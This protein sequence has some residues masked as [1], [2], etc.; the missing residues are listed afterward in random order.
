MSLSEKNIENLLHTIRNTF[1][2]RKNQDPLYI[3]LA[4]NLDRISAP[5]HQI[6]FGRRGSGKSC[7]MIHYLNQAQHKGVFPVYI[8]ADE[9]KKLT[10]PDILIRLLIHI[11]E[12]LLSAQPFLQ[13]HLN[14]KSPLR[15][16]IKILRNLLNS[17][18]TADVTEDIER[19]SAV[20]VEA[21]IPNPMG[22]AKATRGTKKSQGRTSR[23]KEKKLEAL[24]RQL[25]DHKRAI[26]FAINNINS[27]RACILLDDFYLLPRSWHPDVVD[28]LH[29]LVRDT[30]IYLKIA[31]IRHR[32][33]LSRNHPHTIGVELF[34][35][36]EEINL[37]RT[38]DDLETTQGYLA[39]MLNTMG[40]GCN[41]DKVTETHF[42]PNALQELTLASGGV[43]R[44]F[45]NIFVNSVEAALAEQ[46][47]RW[48]TPKWVWKGAGRLTYQTKLKNL[49]EDE[50]EATPGLE[51]VFVD[52]LRF[53]LTEKKKT[54]F[55]I[56]QDE[57]Q[58]RPME[59]EIIQ[60]LMDMKLIHV[61]EP[62]TSAASGRSGRYEAYT[63]DF[64]LF[65]E[66]RRRNIQI[67]EFWIRGEDSHRKGVRESPVYPLD[68]VYEAF[69]G[70][71]KVTPENIL[72]A[73]EQEQKT[74]MNPEP[75]QVE[76][77]Q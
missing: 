66:P 48:L 22:T 40:E 13:R 59:H 8:L 41:L 7:L 26:E 45:L 61:I 12:E 57:S 21:E 43:P 33:T 32:T 64:S 14:R 17:P 5:Q 23:F 35:D 16:S 72:E 18:G 71:D 47:D 39:Q 27:D 6:I 44:D 52:L 58:Q 67:V 77:F 10:Y 49:R 11:D 29:R 36:V 34:Q 2:V 73:T 19:S 53:C 24:E 15:K 65:M 4:N 75:R 38:L 55:L 50:D 62:D 56:S 76:L 37:D 69:N 31:T 42:N 28:Y 1:R 46:Y 60:Q 68:R 54:A 9:Y 30:D 70:T 25:H 63:L 51:R 74:E 3:E 20:A